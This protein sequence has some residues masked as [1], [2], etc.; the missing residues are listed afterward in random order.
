MTVLKRTLMKRDNLTSEEADDLIE[1]MRVAVSKGG[2][3]EE[4]LLEYVGLE[5]DY[6]FDL[7]L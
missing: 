7:F 1:E 3:P 5:P 4:V 6:V 2:D